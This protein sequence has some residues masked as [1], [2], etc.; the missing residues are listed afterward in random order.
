ME[1]NIDDMTGEELGY[2]LELLFENN[3]K[4]AYYTSIYMKKNRPAVILNVIALKEDVE[5]VSSLIFKHSTSLGIRVYNIDRI[6]MDRE[7]FSK[8]TEFGDVS[9]KI[10]NYKDIEKISIEYE[11]LKKIS[12]KTGLSIRQIYNKLI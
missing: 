8:E 11:D 2:L 12:K 1:S 10:S 4:D 7:I 5:S 6:T 9:Y 3:V